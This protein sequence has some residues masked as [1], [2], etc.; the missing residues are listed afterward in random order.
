MYLHDEA[1]FGVCR[2]TTR[3]VYAEKGSAF[4][5]FTLPRESPGVVESR[6]ASRKAPSFCRFV[7]PCRVLASK[8]LGRR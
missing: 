2:N 7:S 8:I 1:A 6:S 4:V 5:F 3:K